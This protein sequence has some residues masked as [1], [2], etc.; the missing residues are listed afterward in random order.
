[1]R[2]YYWRAGK[3]R[4]LKE[5]VDHKEYERKHPDAVAINQP[6]TTEDMESWVMGDG[7]CE[8]LDGCSVEPDGTCPHGLPSWLIA[9]GVV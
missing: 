9:Y 8:A 4:K 5:G 6:P 2:H 3:V 1:M 7:M